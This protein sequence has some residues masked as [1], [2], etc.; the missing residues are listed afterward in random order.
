[1][2]PS[3]R[4]TIIPLQRSTNAEDAD[5]GSSTL[6]LPADAT[7]ASR[8]NGLRIVY[9]TERAADKLGGEIDSGTSQEGDRDRVYDDTGLSHDRVF[10]D[11]W[12]RY[13]F[14]SPRIEK[15]G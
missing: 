12:E 8:T 14:E 15:Q 6:R 2:T 9:D 4:R 5:K 7:S 13:Y 10:K 11:A 3:Y 1:M